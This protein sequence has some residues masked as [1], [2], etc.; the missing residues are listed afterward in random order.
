MRREVIFRLVSVLVVS[1]SLGG[2]DKKGGPAVV[3]EKEHIA[4][5]EAASASSA[6]EPISSPTPGLD[7]V[8]VYEEARELA[9]DEIEVDSVVMK[10][11]ARGT[12]RDPRAMIDEQWIVRVQVMADLKRLKVQTDKA[13][14]DKVKIGDR[15]NVLYRQGK[16]TGTVWAAEIE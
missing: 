11:D 13:H 8:V 10:K 4:A 15:V 3:L 9:A 12:S 16:Y 2:C 1:L 5:R 7:G 6:Q 14:Y